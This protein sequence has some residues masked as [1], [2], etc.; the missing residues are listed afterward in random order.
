MKIA[1]AVALCFLLGG[2]V[3]GAQN[4]TTPAP[5][6]SAALS[7]QPKIDPAKEA[8]I[9]RLLEVAGTAAL[10]RQLMSS[11]EQSMKPVLANSLP[12]GEY[13]DKLIDLFFEKFHSKFDTKRIL[14]LAVVRYDE[15]FSDSE[16]R[17]L[18]DFY[19]TPLGNKVITMLPKVTAELQQD[20]QKLGQ[21]VG[22]DSMIEVLSEHPEIATALH[23]AS[24]GTTPA[25]R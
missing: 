20:G 12:P 6:S 3:E 2:A 5:D 11:M 23:D 9:R 7:A 18:I 13:R 19:Q 4:H 8:D 22:R 25:P 17:G 10:V 1:F 15:N 14:D 21:E 24:H 16:I